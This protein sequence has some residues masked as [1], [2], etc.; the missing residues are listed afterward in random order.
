M[1][2]NSETNFNRVSLEFKAIDGRP[3]QNS[4]PLHVLRG[5]FMGVLDKIDQ[6]FADQVH[7]TNDVA[8]FALQHRVSGFRVDLHCT[9]FSN[10]IG[11][12]LRSFM[13]GT[14]GLVFNLGRERVLLQGI[15]LAEFDA[16]PWLQDLSSW[17]RF[18]I[19]FKTPTYFKTKSGA[20]VLFPEP[21]AICGNLC[22]LWNELVPGCPAMDSTIMLKWISEHV[23]VTSYQLKTGMV[24]L[25]GTGRE[26]TGFKGWACFKIDDDDEQAKNAANFVALLKFA[27]FTNVGGSRTA[28]LGQVACSEISIKGN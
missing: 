5:F 10:E 13:M 19:V 21:A 7:D 2:I 22:M 14:D 12:R 25:G 9:I 3:F 15:S 4:I 16:M 11:K 27:E 23:R 6:Q 20:I 18:K 17:R 26:I 28:G 24:K 8:R 1:M